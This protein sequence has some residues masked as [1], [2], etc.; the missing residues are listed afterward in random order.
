MK[1]IVLHQALFSLA[2]LHLAVAGDEQTNPD[3]TTRD[4]DLATLASLVGSCVFA[5][6][7]PFE[8]LSL[9][10]KIYPQLQ[11]G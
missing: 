1:L 11:V 8:R 7:S 9:L 6:D 5:F 2:L 10:S 4:P 3:P